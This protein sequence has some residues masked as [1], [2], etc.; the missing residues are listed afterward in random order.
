M[1]TGPGK[2][3]VFWGSIAFT[4]METAVK[5]HFSEIPRNPTSENLL[6]VSKSNGEC[7][8]LTFN[9]IRQD[10]GTVNSIRPTRRGSAGWGRKKKNDWSGK[11]RNLTRHFSSEYLMKRRK[12]K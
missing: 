7:E 1:P 2:I 3:V 5:S 10:P 6:T 4:K 9:R 12:G 11:G 8:Y